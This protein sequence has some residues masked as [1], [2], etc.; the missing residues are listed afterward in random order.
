[1]AVRRIIANLPATD[2]VR[3]ARF[4]C[5]VF[6]LAIPLEMGWIAFLKGDARP[7]IEL[8]TASEG[9]SGTAMP[10]ISI[11]VDDLDAVETAARAAGAAPVYGPVTEPWGVRRFYLRDPEGNLINV[12][13]HT[14]AHHEG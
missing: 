6:G 10:A 12:L 14:D 2:P 7:E 8:H 4:Y 1:M 9:G 3:L 11:A 5:D 13:A